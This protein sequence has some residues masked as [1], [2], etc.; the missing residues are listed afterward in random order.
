MII[1]SMPLVITGILS[2]FSLNKLW[3]DIAHT[4]KNGL[5]NDYSYFL[6]FFITNPDI[7]IIYRINV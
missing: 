6:S 3:K 4:K 7:C 2:I 5:D 1:I